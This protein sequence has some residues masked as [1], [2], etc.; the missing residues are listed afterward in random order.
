MQDHYAS[1]SLMSQVVWLPN[2]ELTEHKLST[3]REFICISFFPTEVKSESFYNQR[4]NYQGG[5]FA[6]I[7]E[8]YY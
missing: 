1:P 2:S 4:G 3:K 5:R 6:L 8:K 7:S